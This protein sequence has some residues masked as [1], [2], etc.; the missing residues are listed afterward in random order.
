MVAKSGDRLLHADAISALR[1]VLIPKATVI[2]PN[3]PEAAD[4]LD[5]S[6]AVNRD[7]MQHQAQMPPCTGARSRA[8]KRWASINGRVP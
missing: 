2:T 5:T 1:D 7:L 4:L 6:E 8:V 3:L